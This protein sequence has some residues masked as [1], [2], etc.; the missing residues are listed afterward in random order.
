MIF[1][2][3]YFYSNLRTVL[4][5]YHLDFFDVYVFSDTCSLTVDVVTFTSK[6][7]KTLYTA[8]CTYFH[9]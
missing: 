6:M 8:A 1:F 7:E 4:P 3:F 9:F 5:I 2:L